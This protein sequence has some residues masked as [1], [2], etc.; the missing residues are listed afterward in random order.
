M[1]NIG[2][3]RAL[4]VCDACGGVDDHPRHHHSGGDAG[5]FDPPSAAV[6]ARVAKTAPAA[7]VERLIAELQDTGTTS[8]H[9]DCCRADGCPT[10]DCDRR[11]AGAEDLRGAALLKKLAKGA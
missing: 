1:S 7:D 2:N 11:T 10:G 8:K 6:L 3:G 9:L 5:A 4:Q